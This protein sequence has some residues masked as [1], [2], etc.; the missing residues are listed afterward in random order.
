M[1]LP[2]LPAQ[3][4]GVQRTAKL[5]L[6]PMGTLSGDVREVRVGDRAAAERAALR[7]VT[8]DADRIKPVE[9]LLANSLSTYPLTKASV[10]NLDQMD[11]PFIF[12]YS[13]V[14]Q[15]YAKMAGNL[16]LGYGRGSSEIKPAGC[17][18]RKSHGNMRWSSR[19]LRGTPIHL[20]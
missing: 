1:E 2:K 7:S 17:W 4:N 5:S 8:K 9:S 14:A 6:N 13:L 15:N 16:L 3:L 20:R 12:D 18:K 19:G 10:T 11:Q